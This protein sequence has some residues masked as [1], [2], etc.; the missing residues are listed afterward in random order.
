MDVIDLSFFRLP[1]TCVPSIVALSDHELSM[2]IVW[3]HD[4]VCYL[5]LSK[6]DVDLALKI[7]RS[8][9]PNQRCGMTFEDESDSIKINTAAGIVNDLEIFKSTGTWNSLS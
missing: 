3:P 2:R 8:V 4:G 7:A 5:H 9:D 1:D 6:L